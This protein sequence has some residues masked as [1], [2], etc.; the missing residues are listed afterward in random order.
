MDD[1]S[2]TRNLAGLVFPSAV[3]AVVRVETTGRLL[4]EEA[5]VVLLSALAVT[6]ALLG[7][8]LVLDAEVVAVIRLARP[9]AGDFFSSPEVRAPAPVLS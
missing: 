7:A 9:L 5:R 4:V 8:K 6:G 1:A 2:D 3:P